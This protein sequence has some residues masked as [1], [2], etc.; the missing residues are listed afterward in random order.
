MISITDLQTSLL[1]LLYEI[2][3]TDIKLIIGGGFGIYLKTSHVQQKRIQTLLNVWPEP[4]STNDIDLF[5]RPELLIDTSKIKPLSEAIARLGYK[6]VTGSE[7]YQFVK[8]RLEKTDKRNIKIDILTGPQSRFEGTRVK[9]DD[10]RVRPRPSVGLHAHPVDEAVTLENDLLSIQLEGHLSSGEFFR[11]DIFLP[12]PY[13]FSMMKLFAFR[14]RLNDTDKEY[15]RYHALDIYT[16]IATTEEEEWWYA[17]ELRDQH[18]KHP[19]VQEAGDI[20]LKYFSTLNSPGMLR[21]RES[22]YCRPELQLNEFMSILT[23]LF[24]SAT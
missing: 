1:D 3:D 22:P 24:P 14:D 18:M 20:V 6:I 19:Y 5:L 23:E 12:H 11:A 7:K 9:V 17:L 21:L 16:I 4:R 8:S 13:T 2:K 15:G 10:R